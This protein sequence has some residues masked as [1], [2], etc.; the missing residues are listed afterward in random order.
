VSLPETEILIV[1][2]GAGGGIAAWVLASAGYR[3]VVLEKGPWLDESYFSND[4]VKYGSRDFFTQDVLIE[5]RTMRFDPNLPAQI[6]HVASLSRCVGGGTVHYGGASFRFMPDNFRMATLYGRGVAGSTLD[7]WPISYDELEPHYTAIEQNVVIAGIAPG[8]PDVQQVPGGPT[9]LPNPLAGQFGLHYSKQYPVPPADQRYDAIAFARGAAS[10][11]LHPYPTPCATNTVE[12]HWDGFQHRHKC[13]NCGFCNG[14]GCPNGSKSSTLVTALRRAVATGRCEIRPEC[15]VRRVQLDSRGL[16]RSVLY[17][18]RDFN[19][20]EQP[21]QVIV[22]ACS[23]IDTP[24]LALLSGLD[25]HDPSGMIG[26][27]FTTHHAPSAVVQINDGQHTW[28]ANRGT[29]N[30]ISLDD[31]QD[32]QSYSRATGVPLPGGITFPRAGVVSM[33]GPSPGYPFG[34]GGPISL[35]TTFISRPASTPA[36]ETRLR[37]PAVGGHRSGPPSTATTTPRPSC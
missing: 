12:G 9:I 11:N 7:D 15:Y 1:G 19:M 26:Q 37:Q 4:E 24:R 17:L 22:L 14:C 20:Q 8:F 10:L 5:P 28:D 6:N 25:K 2:S 31:L 23:T 36:G 18:D 16:A 27:N 33:V 34:S 30:T 3:V 13:V 21:A 35:A 29:W 32:L